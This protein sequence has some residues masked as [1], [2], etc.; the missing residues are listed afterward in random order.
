MLIFEWWETFQA[1]DLVVVQPEKDAVAADTSSFS[2]WGS[3]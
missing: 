3:S 2:H 1:T